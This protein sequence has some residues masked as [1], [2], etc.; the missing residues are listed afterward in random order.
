MGKK[1]GRK[2]DGV[3][4][5]TTP[6][7]DSSQ[8]SVPG[9]SQSDF[10]SLGETQPQRVEPVGRGRRPREQYGD[11]KPGTSAEKQEYPSLGAVGGVQPYS[12]AGQRDVKREEQM[13]EGRRFDRGDGRT[14]FHPKSDRGRG[15]GRTQTYQ[16]RSGIGP[17]GDVSFPQPM[18]PPL[19]GDRQGTE[20]QFPEQISPS[21]SSVSVREESGRGRGMGR[22]GGRGRE[23]QRTADPRV[24]KIEETMAHMQ[25]KQDPVHVATPQPKAYIE[26]RPR[27]PQQQ[28]VKMPSPVTRAPVTPEPSQSL[29]PQSL[30]PQQPVS[31][32]VEQIMPPAAIPPPTGGGNG[33]GVGF[34][35]PRRS[36][37]GP[38]VG[39]RGRRTEVEVNHLLLS[40]T[41]KNLV[42]I[43]YDVDFKP[44]APRRLF[45]AAVELFRQKRYPNRYPAFDGR[46]NLY[47]CG[48]LPI[49][50]EA[51]EEVII[52]DEEN[53]GKN[54][55]FKVTIKFANEVNMNQL[56]TYGQSD[57]A[58]LPQEAIQALDVV[59]RNPAARS[60]VTV[61]RSFF[62]RPRGQLID[63]GEGLHL[64]YGFYQSAILGWKPFIN[65]DVAHKGFPA[66]N[67]LIEV[68]IQISGG[69]K[70]V[71]TRP[72][73]ADAVKNLTK[74]LKGLKVEYEIY[75]Q[76]HTRRTYKFVK[77]KDSCDRQRF[78]L[79]SGEEIT[80]GEYFHREKKVKLRFPYMPCIQVG[81]EKKEIYLPIEFCRIQEGQVL[82]R[83]MT[84]NQT[85]EMVRNAA[86]P[87]HER[88]SRILESVKRVN[89]N[90]DQ[91][92]K[93]FGFQVM[94]DH[95]Q[96]VPARVLEPPKLEY[97]GNRPV[98]PRAGVWRNQR[99]LRASELG[100]EWVILNLD[101]RTR[102]ESLRK[103]IEFMGK[104]GSESGIPIGQPCDIKV[105]GSR[106]PLYK[107]KE[108]IISY[109]KGLKEKKVRLVVVVI[110][111]NVDLYS[112]VKQ[113]AELNVGILTQCVKSKTMYKMNASIV[114]NILLKVNSKLN[115]VN[116]KISGSHLPPLMRTPT[117][118]VGADVTHPSPDQ[119]D[120]PSVAA[121]A[122]SHDP[123]AFSYN[124]I[125]R[126]QPPR[127]EIIQDLQEIM[128]MHLMFFF[129]KTRTKPLR[130]I[131]YRDGVSEG[132]FQ[133]VLNSELNAIR[134]ACA[135]LQKD[136]EPKVT[137]L[138][139][140][141]RHHTRFFPTCR[142]DEDGKNKN[143]PAGTIVDTIITHP[144][145]MDFYLVSHASLQGTS[146]P[147][148]YHKLWDDSDINE[149]DLEEL[150]YYLC[151]MFS[152]CTRSVSY[153][154][155]TYYAHLAAFRA[156][157][158]ISGVH[159]NVE[160]LDHEQS[161][162]KIPDDFNLGAPMFFV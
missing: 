132:Q 122:A 44:D 9:P 63:L 138:V 54:V 53:N 78:K 85:A 22:G 97:F 116:H 37:R 120:I 156:R 8:Q 70:N 102:D 110:P 128:K 123:D 158:Y 103:F 30:P 2:G 38:V 52:N 160:N 111:A 153:P 64:W 58:Q 71:I 161:M 118:I 145:E 149:D 14:P 95:F 42:A 108:K 87:P 28:E 24:S 72:L 124:M 51:R 59:L 21:V 88:K 152:R 1:K 96:K 86:R 104:M 91:C 137:F 135:S 162:R 93:E 134:S 112:T 150:T 60:F 127:R 56:L 11:V 100:G 84:E 55:T 133:Q 66:P 81:N 12:G 142:E 20:R 126:L 154:A 47:S 7:D 26:S 73:S 151:H 45:R 109:F 31:R 68:V 40:F 146:R 3:P 43:H 39:T 49:N 4:K 61:G 83:K 113:A 23:M 17:G 119:T 77:V 33:K 136:Y 114:G 76:P 131:F 69:D 10:P 101:E 139:V 67:P 115:G 16:E 106:E 75:N 48:K 117:I 5:P 107:I 65:V 141:K 148:K 98:I 125:W 90:Q 41:R 25:I 144:W 13:G 147:T 32:P 129:K 105:L 143:V 6:S 80:V 18:F 94:D 140:Q 79:N 29:P 92:I 57:S 130:I 34:I 99:F 157:A 35:I 62:T 19:G 27:Q 159:V 36:K 74:Y 82:N 15:R 121:V 89:Y 155:P 46:K 50:D